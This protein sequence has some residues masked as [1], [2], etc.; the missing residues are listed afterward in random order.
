MKGVEQMIKRAWNEFLNETSY[1]VQKIFEIRD[2]L[3]S[4]AGL[5]IF[6]VFVVNR[7]G[8]HGP[9]PLPSPRGGFV[10]RRL[11]VWGSTL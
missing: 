10:G 6:G 9:P 4:L 3:G 2:D 1:T 11:R 8:G 5:V 7:M